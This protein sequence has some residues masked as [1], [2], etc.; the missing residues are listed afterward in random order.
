M[1]R[2]RFHELFTDVQYWGVLCVVQVGYDLGGKNSIIIIKKMQPFK[3]RVSWVWGVQS[4][5]LS[6]FPHSADIKILEVEL[7][8]TDNPLSTPDCPL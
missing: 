5:F 7:T 8:G 2:S 6:S 3:E 4:D 1:Y